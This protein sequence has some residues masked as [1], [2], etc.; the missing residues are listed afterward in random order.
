M[1][2]LMFCPQCSL[3]SDLQVDEDTRLC[4]VCRAPMR[5]VRGL[6]SLHLDEFDAQLG[7]RAARPKSDFRA[8]G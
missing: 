4:Q 8:D 7:E 1:D 6:H 2:R 3:L 5:K